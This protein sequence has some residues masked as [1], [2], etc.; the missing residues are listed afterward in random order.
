MKVLWNIL[1]RIIYFFLY[2]VFRLKLSEENYAKFLQ[3]VQF[4]LVGVSNSVIYYLLYLLFLKLGLYYQV[5]NFLGFSISVLNSFYW[6]SVYV[7]RTED[8]KKEPWWKVLL[9]TYI[10]YAGTGLVLGSF[11]LWFWVAICHF[12]EAIGPI[13][14]IFITTPINFVINKFWAYKDKDV[15]EEKEDAV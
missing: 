2:K 14:N 11:L 7:F 12:P 6:N 1:E 5:A 10:S 4:A 8:E 9:K 3:F 13:L 15:K